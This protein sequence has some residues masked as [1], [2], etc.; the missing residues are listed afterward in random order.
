MPKKK[1]KGRLNELKEKA[2]QPLVFKQ[3]IDISS[4]RY[5]YIEGLFSDNKR[6]YQTS[7]LSILVY[8][9]IKPLHRIRGTTIGF[10]KEDGDGTVMLSAKT[11]G[12]SC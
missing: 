7:N 2:L 4:E 9:S 6:S 3:V 5:T 11:F 12:K 8:V 10:K 1:T